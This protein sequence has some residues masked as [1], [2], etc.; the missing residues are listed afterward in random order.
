MP[1]DTPRWAGGRCG[2]EPYTLPVFVECSLQIA[3][4]RGALPVQAHP[5]EQGHIVGD[6][7]TRQQLAGYTFMLNARE[8]H[9]GH[10]ATRRPSVKT[11]RIVLEHR[12]RL[13]VGERP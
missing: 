9:V 10:V 6:L 2:P 7:A 3:R 5:L 13:R 4:C 8:T 12:A 1:G 11:N